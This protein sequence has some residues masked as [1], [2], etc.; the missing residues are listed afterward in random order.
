MGAGRLSDSP[1]YSIQ[2]TQDMMCMYGRNIILRLDQPYTALCNIA[3]LFLM[4]VRQSIS[5]KKPS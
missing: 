2:V 1:R 5:R 3:R 4:L